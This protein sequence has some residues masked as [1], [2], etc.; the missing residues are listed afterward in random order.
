MDDERMRAMCGR[1]RAQ[2]EELEALLSQPPDGMSPD[3]CA[4]RLEAKRDP[5]VIVSL[6]A[7]VAS[8]RAMADET[9]VVAHEIEADGIERAL[10]AVVPEIARLRSE[11][12]AARDV[13][14]KAMDLAADVRRRER[15]A[16]RDSI[17]AEF[18]AAQRS[19]SAGAYLTG[20]A[21]A[22]ALLTDAEAPCSA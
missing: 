21:R 10:A 5:D 8:L 2:I 9:H 13:A 11:R 4:A 7:T 14:A 18:F 19:G 1:I 6:R 3:A 12:D 22:E 17:R 15:I 20:L 16:A